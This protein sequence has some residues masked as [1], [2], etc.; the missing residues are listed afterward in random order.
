VIG[1]ILRVV[2]LALAL[3]LPAGFA[4]E[5]LARL[6]D[7][8][9]YPVPGELVVVNGH[10]LHLLC[11]GTGSPTVILEAGLGESAL[12]WALV[13]RQLADDTRV[14]AYDRA[15]LAWS[16]PALDAPTAERSGRELHDLLAAAGEDGPF[17]LVG[18]SI[19]GMVAPLFAAAYPSDVVGLLLLDPTNE[20]AVLAAGEPTLPILERRVQGLAAEFGLA[21]LFG[22]SW[23]A[24]AVGASPP[25]E[26]L[27]AIPILYGASS[28]AATVRELEASLESAGQVRITMQ[29]GAWGDVPVV[30]VSAADSTPGDRAHHAALAG[31]SA[32]G[33]HLVAGSGSHYIHYQ[34]PDLVVEQVRSLIGSWSSGR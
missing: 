30:V 22:R 18:H 4:Y 23:V 5:R 16:E 10:G 21:R 13:Q 1:R 29:P 20:E 26:V 12:G 33:I 24:D 31:L 9:R 8:D 32:Q 11:A 2:A 28:Q 27:E 7:A 34:H 19:G 6:G 17:V 15:G 14:C 25:P 3:V